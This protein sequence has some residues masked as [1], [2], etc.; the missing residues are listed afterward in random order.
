MRLVFPNYKHSIMNLAHSIRKEFELDYFYRG[1]REIEKKSKYH[2]K[3]VVLLVFEGLF[4]CDV[5][6]IV[7]E[8]DFLF[9]KRIRNLYSSFPTTKEDTLHVLETGSFV[10]G[11]NIVDEINSCGKYMAYGIYPTGVGAYQDREEMYQR[12]IHFTQGKERKYIF[13]YCDQTEGLL[14]SLN[15]EIEQLCSKLDDTLVLITSNCGRLPQCQMFSLEKH[16]CFSY[17]LDSKFLTSRSCVLKVSDRDAFLSTSK[18]LNVAFKILSTMEAKEMRLLHQDSYLEYD[19]MMI[20]KRDLYFG[21]TN[22]NP[23]CGGLSESEVLLPFFIIEKKKV[24]DRDVIRKAIPN[25]YKE[26]LPLLYETHMK[27]VELRKDIFFKTCPIT[28]AE[29]CDLCA[30]THRTVMLVYTIEEKIVGYVIFEVNYEHRSRLFEDNSATKIH[31]IFVMKEYRR[32]KIGT[33]LYLAVE[34]YTKR[35]RT[36]RIE[37]FV[38]NF[39]SD[40]LAFVQSL[41]MKNLNYTYEKDL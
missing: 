28:K 19:Y 26:I 36:K 39:D 21:E 25:D 34:N 27:R 13:A 23:S 8:G 17:V 7:K 15:S 9:K 10:D 29:F 40:I 33:K 2:Y 14:D 35:Y 32:K 37:F 20:G 6:S 22:F 41:N 31:G 16:P 1:V 18:D 11:N 30:M 5:D 12:I 24:D 38:W 4:A 3:N